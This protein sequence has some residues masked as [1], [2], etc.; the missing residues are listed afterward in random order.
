[1][2]AP[3]ISNLSYPELLKLSEE[4][5]QKIE[6]QR[7]EELKVLADGYIKKAQAS[8]FSAEEAISALQPYAADAKTQAKRRSQGPATPLYQDPANLANTWSGRGL[9]ARWLADYEAQDATS[10]SDGDL[11]LT[12]RGLL[13]R[14]GHQRWFRSS[15]AATAAVRAFC[16]SSSMEPRTRLSLT[17]SQK[18]LITVSSPAGHRQLASAA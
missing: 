9:P 14:I 16:L 7:V 10:S 6:A 2:T 3:D 15:T 18:D 4:L 5:N 11:T 12:W 8:G 13:I 1:M 17:P